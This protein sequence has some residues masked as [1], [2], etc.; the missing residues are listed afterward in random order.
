V[1]SDANIASGRP[2]K[3]SQT[4]KHLLSSLPILLQGL[5]WNP[6]NGCLIEVGRDSFLG[7]GRKAL[8]SPPLLAHLQAKS[9]IFLHQFCYQTTNGPLGDTWLNGSDLQLD[10]EFLT[11]WDDFIKL[12][13]ESGLRLQDK[14]D[15]IFWTGGDGSGQLNAKNVYLAL[16]TNSWKPLNASWRQRI[17]K[18]DCPMK[19]KLFAWLLIEN[20]LLVWEKLQA[21][22][23]EGPSRCILCKSASETTLHV[24]IHCSFIRAIWSNLSTALKFTSLWSGTSIQGCFRSWIMDN[25]NHKMLP[26]H[27][28]WQ[29][30]K[31]RNEAIFKERTP[32]I[33]RISNH[34]LAEAT[35]TSK[36]VK[37]L[38]PFRH[39]FVFPT[40]RTVAWF[41]GASQQGGALCGAGGKI[42][43]NPHTS[44]R[45]TLNCGQGTNMKAELLGAW[46]SLVLA[47]RYTEELILLGDSKLTIDWLN[48]LADFQ[49]AVLGCWKERTKEAALLF[50]KLSFH[51]IFREENS[52]ADT[53]SKKALHLPSGHICFTIWEDGNEGPANKI[54]L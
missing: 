42:V 5:S 45:W 32:S 51:H 25:N 17:W 53:L 31:A 36:I 22:G 54:K 46:A 43:L 26:V 35:N 37:A 27:L 11:E 16:A 50:R 40:D 28:C 20:R 47:S 38:P 21:R 19:L 30:W 44:I 7:L 12:I 15:S 10:P 52:E 14:S 23:W 41:D 4:W 18:D 39:I 1:T 49:V 9:L 8:L 34:F 24:F 48:G 29:V 33:Q 3:G 6:G 2:T 13:K